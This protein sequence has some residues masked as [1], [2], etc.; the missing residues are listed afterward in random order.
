MES[1][2]IVF[3]QGLNAL[4][5]VGILRRRRWRFPLQLGVCSYV[6]YS[7]SLY[8]LANHVTGYPEMPRQDLVSFGLFYIP[9]LP[10]LLGN[11]WLAVQAGQEITRWFRSV[12]SPVGG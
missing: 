7:T 3:T 12:E 9:N 2:N 4:I 5:V 1:F 11:A 8:L 10:W 6:C